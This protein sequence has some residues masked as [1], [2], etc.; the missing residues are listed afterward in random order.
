ME[1]P[2]NIIIYTTLIK[3]FTKDKNF[4]KAL[5]TFN[6][7][8]ATENKPNLVTYNSLLDCAVQ[9]HQFEQMEQIW[10]QIVTQ[11]Q[12]DL[13]PDIIS[14]STYIKGLCKNNRAQ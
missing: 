5:E 1:T 6:K 2:L 4:D 10:T 8:K 13:R 3:G 7:M 12:E 14:Y 9:C 11:K